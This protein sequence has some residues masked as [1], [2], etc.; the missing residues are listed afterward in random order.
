MKR[1]ISVFLA[2]IITAACLLSF[3]G[4]QD[5][6]TDETATAERIIYVS[7]DGSDESGDGSQTAPFASMDMARQAVREM[8]KS[9]G[10]IV[11]EFADG[12][13]Q[14]SDT[15]V[16]DENDSGNKNTKVIYR[17]AKGAHPI[18]SG[19][20]LLDGEWE[21]AAEVDWLKDGLTAYKAHLER[22]CKLRA[23]YVNG[24]RASMTR[25]SAKPVAAAGFY[26]VTQG[27][28]DWA[29]ISEDGIKTATIIP[30]SANLPADTRNP[31][32]IE[33]ESGSTWVKATVCADSL[34]QT[35]KGDVRVNFQMPYAAVAQNLGW[36]TGYSPT[37]QNDII[38]VFEWLDSEGQFY[39]DEAGSTLYYIPREGEDMSTAQVIIPEL[40]KLIEISGSQPK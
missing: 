17:A 6:N 20:R 28:A 31:R 2:A 33:L 30:Q 34:E 22:D 8:K 16:F 40:E 27:M 38:N 4:C 9:G 12:F 18:I 1:F 35:D 13:Y 10:D 24:K 39:F 5:G 11:V 23:I 25:R 19:G 29:W 21:P 26:A 14:L 37:N 3:S 7:P 36:N 15:V 32:N